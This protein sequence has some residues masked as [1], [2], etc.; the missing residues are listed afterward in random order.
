MTRRADETRPL[1]ATVI[2]TLDLSGDHDAAVAPVAADLV[3][4]PRDPLAVNMVLRGPDGVEVGWTFAWELLARGLRGPA[5]EGDVRV[6]P[7][8]GAGSLIEVALATSF[9][10][11]MHFPARAVDDF[12]R[13]VRA[14]AD[15]DAEGVPRALEAALATITQQA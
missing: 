6:R 3:Y 15:A 1:K 12:V 9:G 8:H 14:R 13:K 10:V 11:R 5:G 4:R 7:L 2:G